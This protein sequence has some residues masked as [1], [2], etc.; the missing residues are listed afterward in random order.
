MSIQLVAATNAPPSA[1]MLDKHRL[2]GA[3]AT[4]SLLAPEKSLETQ[5]PS[6]KQVREALDIIQQ[7]VNT[8]TDEL[9]FSIDEGSGRSVVKVVDKMTNEVI[10]QFPSKEVLDIARALNKLQGLLIKEKA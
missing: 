6:I 3:P 10:R 9:D 5:E 4:A 2:A 8:A 1:P 7:A